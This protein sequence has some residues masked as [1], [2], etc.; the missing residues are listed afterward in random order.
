MRTSRAT[1][2]V[3][4]KIGDKLYDRVLVHVTDPVERAAVIKNKAKKYPKQVIAPGSDIMVFHALP[5]DDR[6]V[7]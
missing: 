6:V 5:G 1:R 3:R 4:L 2:T 7:N